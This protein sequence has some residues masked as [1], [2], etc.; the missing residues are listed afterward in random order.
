MYVIVCV[1]PN[2]PAMRLELRRR[3]GELF[4][5]LFRFLVHLRSGWLGRSALRLPGP[6]LAACCCVRRPDG[7]DSGFLKCGRSA[8]KVSK[9]LNWHQWLGCVS[10]FCSGIIGNLSIHGAMR[11]NEKVLAELRVQ[12]ESPA[13]RN[14]A[15]RLDKWKELSR[16]ARQ[17]LQVELPTKHRLKLL[18]LGFGSFC[19]AH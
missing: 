7:M 11:H 16:S 18:G 1:D 14:R 8:R 9:Q 3:P 19:A 6:L 13:F 15:G 17:Q 10:F 12:Q 5:N 4:N 2:F